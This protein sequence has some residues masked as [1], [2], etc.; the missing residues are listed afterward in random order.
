MLPILFPVVCV[1]A[2]CIA[3]MFTRSKLYAIVLPGLVFPVGTTIRLLALSRPD[4]IGE[5]MVL[6]S[7]FIVAG[8]VMGLMYAGIGAFITWRIRGKPSAVSKS[9]AGAVPSSAVRKHL[10]NPV[11]VDQYCAERGWDRS[12]VQELINEGALQGYVDG[13][14]LWIENRDPKF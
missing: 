9:M 4:E 13:A 12:Q 10:S 11:S 6:A 7:P 1:L 3:A 14:G 8:F 5:G 2:G